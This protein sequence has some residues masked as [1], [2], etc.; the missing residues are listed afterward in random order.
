MGKH[1]M[2]PGQ[3]MRHHDRLLMQ[4]LKRARRAN[5]TP[6]ADGDL[7]L[8]TDVRAAVSARITDLVAFVSARRNAY[9]R[10]HADRPSDAEVQQSLERLYYRCT[11]K[12]GDLPLLRKLGGPLT[13][14]DQILDGTLHDHVEGIALSYLKVITS[15]TLGRKEKDAKR[16][17]AHSSLV[18]A[19]VALE[20]L[21]LAFTR[22]EVDFGVLASRLII[23]RPRT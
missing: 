6:G 20:A 1:E 13:W 19:L 4:S 22:R 12:G 18:Q 16:G 9:G 7:V 10:V 3:A 14:E 23:R 5:K 11:R 21:E 2:K 8:Q 15:R 17:D